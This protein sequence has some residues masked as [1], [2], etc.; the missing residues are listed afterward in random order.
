MDP[1]DS[2]VHVIGNMSSYFPVYK[3]VQST[4]LASIPMVEKAR[5]DDEQFS[6]KMIMWRIFEARKLG[7][8]TN[9]LLNPPYP[10]SQ[11]KCS[12]LCKYEKKAFDI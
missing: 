9:C 10:P 2:C 8:L 5:R 6:T 12:D 1:L 11:K 4:D 3:P 7:Q